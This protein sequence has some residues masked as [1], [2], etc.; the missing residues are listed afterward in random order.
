LE[1]TNVVVTDGDSRHHCG[2][3]SICTIIFHL[4]WI[5]PVFT[6]FIPPASSL[7]L[8]QAS[9]RCW[10]WMSSKQLLAKIDIAT[11]AQ[12]YAYPTRV[13]VCIWCVWCVTMTIDAY[14]TPTPR[15]Y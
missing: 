4:W 1:V 15:L 11:R 14:S 7:W 13:E 9:S 6:T 2:W 10:W 3:L 5:H 8:S 12:R